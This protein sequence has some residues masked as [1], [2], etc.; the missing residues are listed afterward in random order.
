MRAS[1]GEMSQELRFVGAFWEP[2]FTEPGAQEPAS[3]KKDQ[4]LSSQGPS[5]IPEV[6]WGNCSWQILG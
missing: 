5:G 3:T 6:A 1:G 2:G 4:G